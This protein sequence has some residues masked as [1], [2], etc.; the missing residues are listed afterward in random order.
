[1][2]RARRELSLLGLRLDSSC[3][4]P[5]GYVLGSYSQ[6]FHPQGK[7]VHLQLNSRVSLGTSQKIRVRI[8]EKFRKSTDSGACTLLM[9]PKSHTFLSHG[10]RVIFALIN[11]M[12]VASRQHDSTYVE[13]IMQ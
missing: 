13:V 4:R 12:A 1:M 11:D 6:P 8:L 7:D 5:S 3:F 10:P 9:C 2:K